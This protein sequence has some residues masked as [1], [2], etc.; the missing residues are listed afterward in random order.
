M[1]KW[2]I[3]FEGECS[4]N[5]EKV[6]TQEQLESLGKSIKLILNLYNDGWALP[7]ADENGKLNRVEF[8]SCDGTLAEPFYW[9][10]NKV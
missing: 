1:S 7:I 3:Y 6:P 2:R 10:T 9:K 4:V 8:I 5:L